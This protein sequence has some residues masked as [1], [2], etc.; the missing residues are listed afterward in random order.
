MR[1]DINSHMTDKPVSWLVFE[2]SRDK[3]ESLLKNPLEREPTTKM[4]GVGII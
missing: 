4:Q 2:E 1:L 3:P